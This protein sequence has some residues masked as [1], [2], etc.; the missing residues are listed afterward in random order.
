MINTQTENKFHDMELRVV[1]AAS[2]SDFRIEFRNPGDCW[3]YGRLHLYEDSGERYAILGD[4]RIQVSIEESLRLC[5]IAELRRT[6]I[7][8]QL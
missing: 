6:G 7:T 3:P 8:P 2:N 4:L 1:G 5:E